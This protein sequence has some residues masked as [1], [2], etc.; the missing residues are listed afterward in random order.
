MFR[1]LNR[2]ALALGALVAP[3]LVW[4]QTAPAPAAAPSTG[5]TPESIIWGLLILAMLLVVVFLL[6]LLMLAVITDYFLRLKFGK[7]IFPVLKAIEL[8]TWLSWSKFTGLRGTSVAAQQRMDQPLGHDYDGI[9]EL[10][11]AAPPIFNYILVGTIAFAV[12]YLLVFHVFRSAPLQQEE[13]ALAVQRAEAEK[14]ER[15]ALAK[16][17]VNETTVTLL[18]AG[19]DLDAGKQIYTQNCVVCHAADGGGLVGPN[20]TDAYWIHG[21]D[22]KDLFR[23][24]KKGGRAGKG[25]IAWE[26]Q[27]TPSQ[28][29]QVASYILK[30]F[31]GTTPAAP[32][33]AEGNLYTPA[34][35]APA[36]STQQQPT[37]TSPQAS[38]Q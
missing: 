27:L 33:A 38:A 1:T 29:A 12:V 17:Q 2:W 31:P 18:T 3:T 32:K 34:G 13:Y 37:E 15:D 7:G 5:P 25:M 19:P 21:G 35:A 22:V 9:E 14:A 10:D 23:V 20:L 6:L 28:M 4:A 36:D 26:S 24:I 16:D 11:N 30:T 8:P